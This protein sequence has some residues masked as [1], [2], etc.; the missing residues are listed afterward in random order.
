MSI[1]FGRRDAGESRS[2]SY[3]DMWGQG[4][5]PLAKDV[6]PL[7]LIPVYAATALIAD[8]V[9]SA[10]WAAYRERDGVPAR[11]ERQPRVVTDPGVNGLDLFSWK[12]QCV[13]SLLLRGNAYGYITDWDSSMVPRTVQW[14]PPQKM[15]VD[16]S[17][18]A[19]VYSYKGRVV[20]RDRILHIP[21]YVVPGSVVGLSPVGQF[22]R[23]LEMGSEAQRVGRN[24]FKRGAMPPAHLKNVK[25]TLSKEQAQAVKQSFTASVS[26][27]EP[28]V[29]GEDWELNAITL[30]AGEASFL[31]A[32]KAT[33]T[34]VAAI[35]RVPPEDIGGEVSGTS[36]TY[37]NLEQDMARFNTRTVR[38]VATRIETVFSRYL[39]PGPEYV[40]FNLDAG[41]RADL[42][43]RYEAHQIALAAGFLTKDEVRALE[44]RGP[45][46]EPSPTAPAPEG[47]PNA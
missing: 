25:K 15:S 26:S 28:F 32:I 34:Q 27:S 47:D 18:V 46:P 30:P 35:Y 11:A 16:E 29:S 44:E 19:P 20:E 17:G 45:L 43:T 24:F 10:P 12:Y 42:K 36:L 6:D 41:V 40:R 1:L 4:L 8:M 7:T 33:A 23:Q 3:Q 21:M 31:T 14:L 38:P 9:A 37:K 13:T 5:D 39:K 22:K 2:I